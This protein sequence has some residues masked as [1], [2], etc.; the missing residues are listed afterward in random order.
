MLCRGLEDDLAL[1]QAGHHV[2][3]REDFRQMVGDD[4]DSCAPRGDRLED[5]EQSRDL[6]APERRGRLVENENLTAEAKGFGDLDQLLLDR[7]HVG[8]HRR[9]ERARDRELFQQPRDFGALL[10]DIDK[11][12]RALVLGVE[13]KVVKAAQRPDQAAFLHD[14]A[15]TEGTRFRG[16]GIG[17]LMPGDANLSLGRPLG[18]ERD[19]HQRGFAGAVVPDDR[20]NA[21]AA[22]A[23]AD[24]L[25][26]PHLAEALA[27]ALHLKNVLDLKRRIHPRDLS[28]RLADHHPWEALNR[29]RRLKNPKPCVK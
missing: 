8:G 18:A 26:H 13:V 19:L 17:E 10:A 11:P 15:E 16:A 28:R 24:V 29:E 14:H 7:A 22:H 9:E 3:H 1:A 12:D 2:A 27:D 23:Y 20:V 4:D 5:A 21:A 6:F 25:E